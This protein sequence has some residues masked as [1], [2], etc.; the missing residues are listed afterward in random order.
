MIIVLTFVS[1]MVALF[2]GG[3][4]YVLKLTS[5]HIKNLEIMVKSKDLFEYKHFE[6]K[7]APVLT[8][9]DPESLLEIFKDKTPQEIRA[10]F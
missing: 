3:F 9:D 10:S 5:D 6:S 4:V 7:P 8:P 1:V 2:V